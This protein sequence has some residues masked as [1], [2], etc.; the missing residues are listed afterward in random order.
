M[1]NSA[2]NNY[3]LRV[4]I[5]VDSIVN[6]AIV[7]ITWNDRTTTRVLITDAWQITRQRGTLEQY[8]IKG[9]DLN[10]MRQREFPLS[11]ISAFVCAPGEFLGAVRALHCRLA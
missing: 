2:L 6:G 4:G 3:G 1:I 10:D 9:F 5:D 7:K 11:I 8:K